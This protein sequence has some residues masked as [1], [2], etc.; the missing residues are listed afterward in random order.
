M[1]QTI[2]VIACEES[3]K[4]LSSFV[5]IEELNKSVR[6]YKETINGN[7]KR[8]DLRKS[9]IA[10]LELLKRH[11]CKYL[12]V[13]MMCKNTIAD[14]MG[15]SYKT[16]QRLVG[17]LASLGMI[18][19]VEMK[20]QKDMLQTSNAIVILPI[21]EDTPSDKTK[22]SDKKA[23]KSPTIC[24]TIK[25]TPVSLKQNI[26]DINKRN[27]NDNSNN[28]VNSIKD[29]DFVAHWV[30]SRFRT[31]ANYFYNDS[32]TIQEFWKVVKQCNRIVNH[33]TGETAFTKEQ[34]TN[35]GIQSI[36][37]FVMKM[38][39]GT[40]MKRGIFAYF[41]GIVNNIM[42]KAYFDDTVIGE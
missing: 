21:I 41:N 25:T 18:K 29:A 23:K 1:K 2:T 11:S 14:K 36:K 37:E 26:K 16:T 13:S 30:P 35:I 19:Q 28:K 27:I 7:I 17:R 38:K 20:R 40:K 39:R 4:N 12:G 31:F 3:Y 34:A 9:L 5:D 8:S 33:V 10:L 32:K 24:P 22:E 42:D 15:T 6:T